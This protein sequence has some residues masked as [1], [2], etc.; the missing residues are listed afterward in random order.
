MAT[1]QQ[2]K[3]WVWIKRGIQS[4]GVFWLLLILFSF[5]IRIHSVQNFTVD[6]VAKYLSS[7]LHTTV[8][9]ED[10]RLSIIDQLHI[11]G[12]LIKDQA[13]D[14]LLFASSIK[15]Q[16]TSSWFALLSKRM[17]VKSIAISDAQFNFQR[18]TNSFYNNLDQLIRQWEGTS[19]LDSINKPTKDISFDLDIKKITL[20]N[21]TFSQHD[22]T[23]GTKLK[24]FLKKGILQ[25][26]ALDLPKRS[27]HIHQ[28]FFDSPIFEIEQSERHDHKVTLDTILSTYRPPTDTSFWSFKIDRFSLEKGVFAFKNFRQP[29]TLG[30]VGDSVLSFKDMSFRKIDCTVK[31]FQFVKDT[32]TG[33]LAHFEC[34]EQNGFQL[35]NFALQFFEFSPKKIGLYG[36]SLR[37]PET[38]LGDTLIFKYKRLSDFSDFNN[39]VKLELVLNNSFIQL[40]DVMT[41]VP[42][43]QNDPFFKKNKNKKLRVSGKFI[44]AIND[45]SAKDLKIQLNGKTFIEGNFSSN[46][47]VSPGEQI[48]RLSLSDLQTN[49]G[50][51][52]EVIPN[53]SL[54]SNF[55][56]LGNIRFRGGLDFL[57]DKVVLNGWLNT[58]L[59]SAELDMGFIGL[60]NPIAT[61]Y[62]GKLGLKN[63]D[64]GKWLGNKEVGQISA[65]SKV[66]QGRGLTEKSAQAR[67]SIDIQSVFYKNY[68]YKNATF[69][70]ELG[71]QLF[72]GRLSIDD[73]FMK[74]NFLGKVDYKTKVP[75]FDFELDLKTLQLKPLYLSDQDIVLSGKA[76]VDLSLYNRDLSQSEGT[77]ILRQIVI[78]ETPYLATIDSI[79]I[80]SQL[81]KKRIRHIALDSEVMSASMDGNFTL[82]KLGD[83]LLN[84]AHNEYPFYAKK[85]KLKQ[86]ELVKDTQQVA[87]K[88][89]IKN[90]GELTKIFDFKLDTIRDVQLIA[91]FN[92]SRPNLEVILDVDKIRYDSINFHNFTFR[93]KLQNKQKIGSIDFGVDSIILKDKTRIEPIV[94]LAIVEDEVVDYSINY[95]PNSKKDFKYGLNIDGVL[96]P[97]DSTRFQISI[98][99]KSFQLLSEYWDFSPSNYIRF[100][101][102]NLEIKEFTLTDYKKRV[103]NLNQIGQN[104]MELRLDN[105]GFDL[106]D[107]LWRYKP[108]D[109]AGKFA[110]SLVVQDIYKL[111]DI[112][113]KLRSDSLFIN[114]DPARQINLDLFT[115]NINSTVNSRIEISNTQSSF[116][117]VG[118]YNTPIYKPELSTT[119][120]KKR[121]PNYFDLDLKASEFPIAFIENFIVGASEFSG[122]INTTLNVNGNPSLPNINGELLVNS[123]SFKVDF[124][125]TRYFINQ[126]KAII[127]NRWIDASKAVVT[128]ETGA[129]AKLKGGITHRNLKDFG[130]SLDIIAETPFIALNTTKAD[131]DIFYGKGVG[132]GRITFTGSFSQTNIQVKATAGVGTKIIIPVSTSQEADQVK[133]IQFPNEVKRDTFGQYLSEIRGVD[134]DLNLT[135]TDVAQVDLVF[136]ERSGDILS[137]RGRGDI[138]IYLDRTG[139]M[140]MYGNYFI[141]QGEYLFTL[142]NLV[143]KPFIV[144]RGGTLRWQGDPFNATIDINA[145]YKDLS[146]SVAKLIPEFLS[147]AP[148]D[149]QNRAGQPTDIDLTMKLQGELFNPSITFDLD[150][151]RLQGDL[152]TYVDN[153][154]INLE[155]DQNELNKQVF[156]LI[157]LGQFIPSEF[158]LSGQSGS[159]IA[160]S[161]VSELIAN[162]LSILVTDFF[163][164]LFEDVDVI[165]SIDFDLAYNRF[166][167]NL[168]VTQSDF[169]IYGEE[170]ELRQKASLWND[171]VVLI[172]GGNVTNT[173]TQSDSKTFFGNDI[174]VEGVLNKDRTLKLRV[175]QIRQPS[176][177]EGADVKYGIGLS[178]RKEFSSFKAF[179]NGIFKKH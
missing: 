157:V 43:L 27:I 94:F 169:Y 66:E 142:F 3:R 63:F 26:Q 69:T 59:G 139:E 21:I 39:N 135:L 138:Q 33:K 50:V 79:R 53:F 88:I 97:Y 152:K 173:A 11:D 95:A 102:G 78:K 68:N 90:T 114:K 168:D 32:Y 100:G 117:L 150:F 163:V 54:P 6:Q 41:F 31:D 56:K 128:D 62:Y 28:V 164:E 154:M 20:R 125:N 48:I 70:G 161:T 40:N 85:L 160:I 24:G 51:L 147:Y 155:Q 136:D 83:A 8:K 174:V 134:L 120:V 116:S 129:V 84:Y 177:I 37:T 73:E 38:Y 46:N 156:G 140:S 148:T 158:T 98:D 4:F 179:F 143:N 47:L 75:K 176:V 42:T 14:T 71:K 65:V 58:E 5:I 76:D 172:V 123:A 18:D 67:L 99:P 167:N 149:V 10:V 74:M 137:G 89:D 113:L 82:A 2:L 170:F 7:A 178:Y 23:T 44:G 115:D 105:F 106:I 175:Y 126:Q 110:L 9:V 87:L 60:D 133:F 57:F 111:K 144:Q 1:R 34:E 22:E 49:V 130:L 146:T 15:A 86:P 29:D 80:V 35:Q 166:D 30:V 171:K 77:A 17:D 64:L 96:A 108:L 52:R 122:T 101:D 91:N 92:N 162:Q 151:P 93:S 13:G 16:L 103:I 112:S 153:K 145:K 131:N 124:L 119:V 159:D 118:K 61:Q 25:L 12:V 141:E 81:D 132:M 127:N 72:E 165:S 36:L 45:L 19:L 104:G 55:D 121:E 107:S 109:F